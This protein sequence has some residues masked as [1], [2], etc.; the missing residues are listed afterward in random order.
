MRRH[1]DFERIYGEF[2]NYYKVAGLADTEYYQWIKD[3]TLDETL[4]YGQARESLEWAK[5]M[6]KLLKEDK[7]NKYYEVLVGFPIKSMNGN[8]YK[9]R[10]LI[11]AATTMK[12][13]SPSLNHKD[14]FWFSDKNP[15]N[16][17]G[18]PIEVVKGKYFNGAVEC[19]LKVPRATICPIC[20]G[21][22][23][24]E[25]IDNRKIVNV[26]LEGECVGGTDVDGSCKG[27]AFNE[28][29]FTL[30]TT[31]VLPGIPMA[32]IRPME[33][34][35]PFSRSSIKRGT[36][37]K[38]V[39]KRIIKLVPKEAREPGDMGMT[40]P[41]KKGP[42]SM[43]TSVYNT[44]DLGTQT[45]PTGSNRFRGNLTPVSQQ[46]NVAVGTDSAA[47]KPEG[48]WTTT[49]TQPASTFIYPKE[50]TTGTVL[51]VKPSDQATVI[52][53]NPV[54]PEVDSHQGPDRT[55]VST[56]DLTISVVP[57]VGDTD[58]IKPPMLPTAPE[59][60]TPDP[61]HTCSPG[62]HW[63]DDRG[64][65]PDVN[66]PDHD[67][68]PKEDLCPEGQ[69]KDANGDCVDD[70][71]EQELCPDGQHKDADGNCV[72]DE[73]T[74]E[75]VKR[76]KADDRARNFEGKALAWEQRYVKEHQQRKIL[77]GRYIET[78]TRLTQESVK[79]EDAIRQ[80]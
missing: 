66:E 47:S 60:V 20:N 33:S 72:D 68:L 65:V 24:T 62:H 56:P 14:R 12:G 10:D 75:R 61:P 73:A 71:V 79:K 64:C 6:I 50:G 27:F 22:K 19:I 46:T 67:V 21:K 23:M 30:L 3:M 16:R 34:Y 80:M 32:R 57:P 37:N 7:E 4:E 54:M 58:E 8:V 43:D 63:T 15:R 17:W 59:T 13:A 28:K 77:E 53:A 31:D 49:Q 41:P 48:V 29:T 2:L 44:P 70:T 78:K 38:N 76:W 39:K 42:D 45:G 55:P 36:R 69:H 26:S 25:L 5:D 11:A 18:P 35:L 74:E 40:S 1:T 9:E 52:T 51:H